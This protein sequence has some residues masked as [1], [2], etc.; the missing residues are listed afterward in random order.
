MKSTTEKPNEDNRANAHVRG[1][2]T[3][4]KFTLHP[5][6]A[7]RIY[8]VEQVIRNLEFELAA[9]LGDWT[10]A[11]RMVKD[12][13]GKPRDLEPSRIARSTRVMLT[14]FAMSRDEDA[15]AEILFDHAAFLRAAVKWWNGLR[16]ADALKAGELYEARAHELADAE[17][18]VIPERDAPKESEPTGI[19]T[20]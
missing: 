17:V 2:I 8:V 14:F 6:S 15:L 5:F 11:K 20:D 12:A 1:P 7:G 16:A 19:R 13:D 10:A 18:E 4:G 9:K 3:L